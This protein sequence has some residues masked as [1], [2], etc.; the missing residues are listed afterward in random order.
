[1]QQVA[2]VRCGAIPQVEKY[3]Q[4][5][6]GAVERDQTVVVEG[7][8]GLQLGTVLSLV[9]NTDESN[10]Q[11]EGPQAEVVRV[12]TQD[13]LDRSES[14]RRAG[15]DEFAKWEK[16]IEEWKL[17]LQLIDLEWTLEREKL[18]LYVLNERGPESTKLALYAA[19]RGLG[20]VEIIPVGKDGPIA[21][22]TQSS[23]W[24]SSDGG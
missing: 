19:A 15:I 13:D 2:L 16:R 23:G 5:G 4:N 17:D 24:C 8:H 7:M 6:S 1:M 10:P 22:E 14:N 11:S 18:I 9:Q 3:R 20:P 12:A 21:P